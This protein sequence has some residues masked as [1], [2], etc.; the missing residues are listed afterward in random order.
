M[1]MKFIVALSAL[2]FSE[3]AFS[4]IGPG[5]AV[6]MILTLLGLVASFL[7]LLLG[8]VYYPLKRLVKKLRKNNRFFS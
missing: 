4:Y 8:I 3:V 7:L 1:P 6:G 5:I 2:F